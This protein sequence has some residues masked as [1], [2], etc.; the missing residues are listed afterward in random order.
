M[1]N[2]FISNGSR[3]ATADILLDGVSSTKFEQNSGI[4]AP[5]YVPSVDA[6]QEFKV[7]QSNFSAEFGFTGATVV[8][9]LTRSGTNQ[10]H[11]TL[12]D[13]VRTEELNANDWLSNLNDH[14]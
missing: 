7:Q 9:L 14:P 1:A 10:F 8:N 4:L 2:N 5:T 3:N 13:F 12:Y 6:V 11:G